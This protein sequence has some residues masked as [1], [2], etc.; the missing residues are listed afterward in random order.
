MATLQREAG[1]GSEAFALAT[2]IAGRMWVVA[3]PDLAHEVLDSPDVRYR[4]GTANRRILPVLPEGTLLT[5][6]G[7]A[8]RARRSRRP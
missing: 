7:P 2:L 8:H 3:T 6:D 1:S 5:L 4:A